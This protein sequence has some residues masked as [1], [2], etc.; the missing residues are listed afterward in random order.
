[1]A[2]EFEKANAPESER[3]RRSSSDS[4]A[5]RAAGTTHPAPENGEA[6]GSESMKDPGAWTE[7]ASIRIENVEG[8]DPAF[9]ETLSPVQAGHPRGR[10]LAKP[11]GVRHGLTGEQRILILDAWKRSELP[12]KD[13]AAIAG[14]SPLTLY[15]WRKKFE[16]EGPG[17][18]MEKPR[19][20]GKGSRL[21]ELTRRTILMLKDS[22]PE[23]GCQRIS[24]VLLRGPSLSASPAAIAQVLHDAGYAM[25][26]VPTR[27]H[28]AHPREF[29]RAKP[30]QLWQTDLFTFILKRQ[31]RRVYLVAFMDD[32]SRFVVGYGL[33]ASQ[34]TA[35]VLEVLRAAI[36][37]YRPPEEILTDNGAQYVTWRGKSAFTKELEKQ[38]IRQIIAS[39]HRPQTLG[40]L[41]R[42]WGTLW[43][44]CA[45]RAVF[46]DL[47]DARRRIGLF[48]DHYNFQRPHQGIGGLVPADRF[49]SAAPEVLRTLKERVAANALDLARHGEPRAPFYLTG[50]VGGKS[51][52]VHAEGERVILR[53]EGGPR[54]EV[55]L[56][57]PL[58]A[59]ATPT[60]GNGTGA[61]P[62]CPE[63]S[64]LDRAKD[65]VPAPGTSPLDPALD[66]LAFLFEEKKEGEKP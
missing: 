16:S 19:G 45:E 15:N 62:L 10:R 31:N 58:E 28:P 66:D 61:A 8:E 48:I 64:P 53:R 42:F 14:V 5:D 3:D 40:K 37:S 26:D 39:P 46:L 18:L 65:A 27:P 1:M 6:P 59:G 30:N 36:S 49:F 21:P 2:Q 54:E 12:A 44:E 33:H 43:R 55:E 7:D 17:A 29:E 52:S 32:H 13:F 57:R 9:R 20:P 34:S 38:G 22:N 50:Q 47:E 41:E 63:G 35:L 60:D 23:W 51:F 4:G 24:D 25:E 11:A 56:V